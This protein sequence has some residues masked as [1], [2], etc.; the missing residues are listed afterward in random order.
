MPSASYQGVRRLLQSA[1]IAF[2][3]YASHSDLLSSS[4]KPIVSSATQRASAHYQGHSRRLNTN[5]RREQAAHSH[6]EDVRIDSLIEHL[7]RF[8]FGSMPTKRAPTLKKFF[9]YKLPP[10][11]FAQGWNRKTEKNNHGQHSLIE[12][13][14]SQSL[15]DLT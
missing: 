14:R 8:S 7:D 2:F 4:S 12:Q 6:P 5:G 10:R 11:P 13:Y 3:V 1:C 15:H 9:A